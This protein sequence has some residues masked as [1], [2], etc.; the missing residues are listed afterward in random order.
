[1]SGIAIVKLQGEEY[2][3]STELAEAIDAA[4]ERARGF[5]DAWKAAAKRYRAALALLRPEFRHT[6]DALIERAHADGVQEGLNRLELANAL[7]QAYLRQELEQA[8]REVLEEARINVSD[9]LAIDDPAHVELDM[10]VGE[11]VEN[12]ADAKAEGRREGHKLFP[13]EMRL[14]ERSGRE[15]ERERIRQSCPE[16][17]GTGNMLLN[18]QGDEWREVDCR[19][20][21]WIEAIREVD[22]DS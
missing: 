6:V 19:C 16:C 7:D 15:K 20:C 3:C 11:Y 9:D 13:S 12:M 14:A 5:R 17:G 22:D 1:M 21:G 4:L 18:P 10:T 8:R 2:E